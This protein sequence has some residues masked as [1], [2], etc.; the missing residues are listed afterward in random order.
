M[1]S[2]QTLIS[3]L[4]VLLTSVA[5]A[6]TRVI[7]ISPY[8]LTATWRGDTEIVRL[9]NRHSHRLVWQRTFLHAWLER[10]FMG[11]SRD[12]RALAF[13]VQDNRIYIQRS[14]GFQHITRDLFRIF[15]WRAGEQS[16]LIANQ[17]ILQTYDGAFDFQWSPGNS[18]LAFRGEG[19]GDLDVDAGAICCLDPSTGRIHAGPGGVRKM[20][21]IGR[22]LLRYWPL[23]WR[24]V[25][26]QSVVPVT[27]RHSRLWRCP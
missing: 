17:N 12:H 3:I 7:N 8:R 14:S 1:I 9:Y 26:P 27:A 16:K 21:W 10:P 13:I 19:S 4:L 24:L 5:N 25:G 6:Q 22:Y 11:W 2:M 18:R 20:R 15:I 23:H